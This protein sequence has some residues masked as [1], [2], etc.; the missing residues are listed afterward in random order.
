MQ[1]NS[2]SPLE[3]NKALCSS[4]QSR[5]PQFYFSLSP[6]FLRITQA[7]YFLAAQ[8]HRLV[9]KNAQMQAG[10]EIKCYEPIIT[11]QTAQH[12]LQHQPCPET[13]GF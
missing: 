2:V 11:S 12:F 6:I 13:P 8:E 4:L 10:Q 1:K 9:S 5:K 3:L 7:M